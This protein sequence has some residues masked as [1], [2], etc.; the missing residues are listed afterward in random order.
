MTKKHYI[1]FAAV[2][3]DTL[4]SIE[5]LPL[6][7]RD[8]AQ[9]AIDRLILESAKIMQHDNSAFRPVQF[10]SACGYS[11]VQAFAMMAKI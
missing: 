5:R 11:A 8:E 6:K 10:L 3:K 2:F 4:E 7:S 1:A 9:N